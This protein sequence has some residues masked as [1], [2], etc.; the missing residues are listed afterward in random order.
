MKLNSI[1]VLFLLL[2][3]SNSSEPEELNELVHDFYLSNAA[4]IRTT[5][6]KSS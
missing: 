1:L 4:G 3:C 2:G 5:T 6:F